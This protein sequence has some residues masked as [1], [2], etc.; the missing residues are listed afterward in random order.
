MKY[1]K[2]ATKISLF[3]FKTL[4]VASI[5]LFKTPQGVESLVSVAMG[6]EG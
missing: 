6:P 4:K 2:S 1:R 3:K 5:G